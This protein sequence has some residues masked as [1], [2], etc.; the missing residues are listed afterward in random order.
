MYDIIY[1]TY[2]LLLIDG[3]NIV[4]TYRKVLE[5]KNIPKNTIL[6]KDGDAFNNNLSSLMG[7]L[8]NIQRIYLQKYN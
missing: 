2:R 4:K 5:E 6:Y 8:L 3:V 7:R 1:K